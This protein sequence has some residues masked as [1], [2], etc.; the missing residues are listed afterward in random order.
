MSIQTDIRTQELLAQFRAQRSLPR[1]E[2]KKA[3][4]ESSGTV[5]ASRSVKQDLYL[6]AQASTSGMQAGKSGQASGDRVEISLAAN[7]TIEAANGI[8]NDSVV[9][10]INKAL[11]EAGIDLKVEDVG[12]L[13][14]DTSP[15]AT[16]RRIVD[17]SAGFL[18]AHQQNH[19]D[20]ADAVRVEGFMSLV[21]G[22]IKDGFQKAR[23]FLEGITKLSEAVDQNID[24]TFELTNQY[25]DDF[26]RE[27]LDLIQ[28]AEADPAAAQGEEQGIPTEEI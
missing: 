17:F 27:Q 12:D 2:G 5:A 6:Q 19:A 28:R 24:R 9:E 14:I 8:L 3:V 21:R 1:G 18:E 25:L 22:A 4:A 11:Q 20:E 15:E 7:L 13:N 26:H 16:A 10:Q 23:D